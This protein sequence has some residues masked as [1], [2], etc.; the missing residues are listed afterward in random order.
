MASAVMWLCSDAASYMTG[1]PLAVDGGVVL[2]GLGT[3][4]DDLVEAQA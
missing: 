4:F 1:H 2:G 3:R